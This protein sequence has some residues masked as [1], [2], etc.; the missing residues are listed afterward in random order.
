MKHIICTLLICFFTLNIAY[1]QDNAKVYQTPE[2]IFYGYDFS[3]FKLNEPKRLYDNN[4]KKLI[5]GW[6]GFL[7]EHTNEIDLQKRFKKSKVTFDFDYTLAKVDSLDETKLV[8]VMKHTISKD[9]IQS[10]ISNYNIK[11]K[12]GIGFVVILESF[13]KINDK[14]YAYF[15]F[16]RHRNKKG[17]NERLFFS[18]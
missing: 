4:I 9:S 6:I 14:C 1:T 11:Q 10:Y 13:E 8:S 18:A 2:I 17:I 12:E 5:P 7:N 16:F 3:H 15:V